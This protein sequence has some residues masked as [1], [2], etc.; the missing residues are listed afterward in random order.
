MSGKKGFGETRPAKSAHPLSDAN[1][2]EQRRRCACRR[3]PEIVR[4]ATLHAR[5]QPMVRGRE[6]RCPRPRWRECGRA[7]RSDRSRRVARH[8][9]GCAK[10]PEARVERVE[11]RREPPTAEESSSS[12][13]REKGSSGYPTHTT[14]WPECNK[15]AL[16][17]VDFCGETQPL[18]HS[19]ARVM[20]SQGHMYHLGTRHLCRYKTHRVTRSKR[21]RRVTVDHSGPV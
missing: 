1:E 11:S 16:E 20:S 14:L 15:R 12:K 9:G 7:G 10:A 19:R 5:K 8:L 21:P 17:G 13:G 2:R 3:A 18:Y 4:G 6:K